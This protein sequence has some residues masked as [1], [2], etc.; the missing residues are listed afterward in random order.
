M[1]TSLNI[2]MCI[3]SLSREVFHENFKNGVTNSIKAPPPLFAS[4]LPYASDLHNAFARY[5]SLGLHFGSKK[6]GKLSIVFED[7]SRNSVFFRTKVTP[8]LSSLVNLLH[9]AF[10]VFYH[11]WTLKRSESTGEWLY[12]RYDKTHIIYSSY[13]ISYVYQNINI[14]YHI[15][16]NLF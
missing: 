8:Y 2:Y 11:W 4:V 12:N 9:F 7:S 10:I 16:Y 5:V 1:Y 15:V 3:L 6:T 14:S 13:I